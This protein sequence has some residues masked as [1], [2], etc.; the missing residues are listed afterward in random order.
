M[1]G[2]RAFLGAGLG[3]A[4]AACG[5]KVAALPPGELLSTRHRIGHR[6]RD[7]GLPRAVESRKAKVVIVGGGIAGLSAAWRL[8]RAG[9]DDFE[10][11][12]LED[13]PGG[14]SRYGRNAVTAYPWGAHYVTLPTRE[15]RACRLLLAELGVLHGDPEAASPRYDERA[16][17]QA[18]QERL[19][20]NGMWDEGLAPIAGRTSAEVDEW[21]RFHARMGEFGALRGRDGRRAFS[22][23]VDFSSRDPSLVALDGVSMDAWLRAEGFDSEA[24]R[25][26]VN[27]ACRDDYGC[28][29]RAT[30]AWAAIH[31]FASRAEVS[32]EGDHDAVLT[33][34]EGNGFVVRSLM[35]R[36]RFPVTPGVLVHRV[37]EKPG[38]VVLGAW[39]A[40]ENRAVE[41]RA[42]RV[43]WAAPFS[44]AA[45][46]LGG[47][48][49]AG[50][51]REFES[52]PW[53]VA[54][55]ALSE[56][57]YLHHGAP[58]A[59]DNVLYDSPGLGYVVATHQGIATRPGPTVLTWYMPLTADTPAAGRKR[60]LETSR[61]AWARVALDD[62]AKP[63]PEI[64]HIAERVDIFANGHAMVRPRPGLIFG[65]ARE[66]VLA[67]R[68]RLHFAHADGSGIS[69]FEEANDRGVL[70]AEQV[71][72]GFGQ[73]VDT[74][75]GKTGSG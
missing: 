26:L 67:H 3:L 68:G 50:A 28:D 47:G 59:W 17:C 6:L 43:V 10:L 41:I 29:Y 37:E 22:I 34:P 61:D 72:A 7:G 52:A 70:A 23:P 53:L 9:F 35:D 4:A 60:L 24:V 45:R 74:F 71:L 75:R 65:A 73:R 13:R 51:L 62:L 56:P 19:Y 69:I 44:F 8:R 57:P 25:W 2:R 40:A 31:Y 46:A 30:S 11:L 5:P 14:N 16:L 36:Y 15:A 12:E 48:E 63:H 49:L 32:R 58:L 20:R 39:L 54:N 66:R 1:T 38:E 55:L 42:E 21:Q 27:Y 64:R 18:P 33:W